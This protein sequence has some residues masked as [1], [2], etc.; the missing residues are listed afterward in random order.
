MRELDL[1]RLIGQVDADLVEA[2]EN[3]KPIRRRGV[4]R[5]FLPAC[6]CLVVIIALA[7]QTL[8]FLR[9]CGSSAD[10][11]ANPTAEQSTAQDTDGTMNSGQTEEPT[12]ESAQMPM[13]EESTAEEATPSDGSWTQDAAGLSLLGVGIGT[14]QDVV[15]SLLGL[16]VSQSEPVTEDGVSFFTAQYAPLQDSATVT[17]EYADT[18]DGYQVN[19]LVLDS[20][21]GS[22]QLDNGVSI[23][24]TR[25]ALEDLLAMFDGLEVEFQQEQICIQIPDYGIPVTID[26]EDDHICR[27]QVGPLV[28]HAQP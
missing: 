19:Q 2:A 4:W 27:I 12:E 14:E 7:A 24:M 22:L 10:T 5:S 3:W 20:L 21:S 25:Q 13:E 23:G 18:G 6:A 28:A 1:L 16:P 15:S 8:P 17:V 11:M 26:L 9:G